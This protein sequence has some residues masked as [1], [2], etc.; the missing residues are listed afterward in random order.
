MK[1]T[2]LLA[3]SLLALALGSCN[4]DFV[5]IPP[6]TAISSTT[7]YKTQ[8]DF[9]Q[10]VN[11]TYAGLR[12]L[13][14]DAY[15]MGEM[16]SDNTH[17]VFKSGDR[18][19][20]NVQREQ[21]ADFLEDPTNTYIAN[22]W[23]SSYNIIARAN[24]ILAQIDAASFDATVKD[25]L[26]GQALFLRAFAYYQLVRYFGDVPL[27]L[28]PV[29]TIEETTLPKTA[30]AEIYTQI[31]TDAKDAAALL[32]LKAAQ[33]KGRVTSGSAKTLLG[34]VYLTQKQYASAETI[35]REV[36]SS[37]QYALLPDYASVYALANK[38]SA[39]SVFEVQYQ[40][41]TQG[42]QSN[43][44]YIFIPALTN[45]QPITGVTPSN[46][47]L[48]GGWNTPTDD[49]I[50]SY[51][52]GDKRKD[53][54]I[55]YYTV[56]GVSYPYV[57]KYLHAHALYNNTD[58]NWP[59]YRYADVL[60][61]LAESLNEQGKSADALPF[62]N[63]VRTRAG[64][65][66][67]TAAGQTALRDVIAHERRVELAFE[68]HRWLDLVR[69][70]KAIEVMTAYGAKVKANPQ[71]YYYPLGSGALSQSYNV[72]QSRLLFPIPDREVILNPLLK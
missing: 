58:D 28:K 13:Y 20:Q 49:L 57:K 3:A 24:Q 7:F 12:S 33:E 16:R 46:N 59:V 23:N 14:S 6:Q 68:N 47:Q 65:A 26:K 64:L 4:K 43:F 29:T 38:N 31:I 22:K 50:S 1:S 18:G 51:E 27:H 36:V 25:N 54:S 70:G 32:P 15:V 62:L 63:Q 8:D 56:S 30:A 34:Y 69:T 67:T 61:L 40:Q 9:T 17:Y 52:A 11:G 45:T 21:I 55:G 37:G 42:L 60:L 5:E 72:T 48:V 19:G 35:L 41:G 66:A 10:A 2:T 71:K 44:A 39:E 53:A